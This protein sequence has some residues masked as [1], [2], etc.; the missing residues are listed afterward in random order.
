MILGIV[1]SEVKG[2]IKDIVEMDQRAPGAV[3]YN[4]N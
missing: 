2:N 3:D 1:V 4:L